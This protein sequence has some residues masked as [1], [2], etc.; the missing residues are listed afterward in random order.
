MEIKA[1]L[2]N[3]RIGPRKVRLLA[4][5]IRGMRAEEAIFQLKYLNKKSSVS[6]IKLVESAIAN[7]INNANL[8][9]SDLYIKSIT[10]DGG[11]TIK[12]WQPKAFGRAG[13]I[14]K[15]GSIVNIVL[16]DGKDLKDKKVIRK[17]I[18]N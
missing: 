18:R 2:N 14:R 15:R 16:K 7:G 3:L 1:K 5:L 6:L 10:V 8:N 17:E 12:R 13:K 11:I 4:D 9:R